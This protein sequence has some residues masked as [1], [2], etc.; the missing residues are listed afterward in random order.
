MGAVL[1]NTS[2]IGTDRGEA[3]VMIRPI[4]V[5]TS[6][7][8]CDLVVSDPGEA[9]LDKSTITFAP[10]SRL[11]TVRIVGV[12]DFV[13]DGPQP[14]SIGISK[15]SSSDLMYNFNEYWEIGRSWNL[16]VP[17]PEIVSIEP[18]SSSMVGQQVTIWGADLWNDTHVY[19]NGLLMSGPPVLR[20]VLR[21]VDASYEVR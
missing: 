13:E 14:F 10:G 6:M 7:V 17:F 20:S 21:V 8:T 18:T 9:A 5:L 16:D 15:C 2:E 19:V 11:H 1:G 3:V 4:E 12:A